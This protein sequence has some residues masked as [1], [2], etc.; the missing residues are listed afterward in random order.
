[1]RIQIYPFDEL[2]NASYDWL[3]TSHHFSFG[4]YANPARMGFRTLRVINDDKIAPQ[5]G[6]GLHPH[7]DMEIITYVREGAITHTDSLGHEGRTEAGDVQVMS[8]GTGIRH[9]EANKEA[10]ETILFQIWILPDATGHEPRWETRNFPKKQGLELLV[11]GKPEDQ[12]QKPLFIHQNAAIWRLTLDK[13]QEFTLPTDIRRGYYLLMSEG[14]I[15]FLDQ[16]LRKG[17]GAEI[18]RLSS[19]PI[20]ANEPSELLIIDVA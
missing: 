2:G 4:D 12:S 8:A 6:F 14:E 5:R 1:M 18:E 9:A 11:S 16:T 17:D 15:S 3:E 13:G 7:R 19:I 20:H 10:I